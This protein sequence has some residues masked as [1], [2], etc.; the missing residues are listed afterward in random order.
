L[1]HDGANKQSIQQWPR[2]RTVGDVA[3]TMLLTVL[4]MLPAFGR[5][6]CLDK[7]PGA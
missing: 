1:I 2:A 3:R 4:C 5:C 7:F 6:R